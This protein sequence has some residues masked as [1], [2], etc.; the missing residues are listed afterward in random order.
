MTAK[1][2]LTLGEFLKNVP[3]GSVVKLCVCGARFVKIPQQE[4]IRAL[5][6]GMTDTFSINHEIVLEDE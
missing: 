5:P 6:A 3:D 2:K 1:S 4:V